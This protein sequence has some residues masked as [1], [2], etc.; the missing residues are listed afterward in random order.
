MVLFGAVAAVLLIVC[1]NLSNLL[2][3]RSVSRQREFAVR[4]ALGA[5]TGRLARQTLTETLVLTLAGSALGFAAAGWAVRAVIVTAPL[6]LPDFSPIAI[7]ARAWIFVSFL[8]L[9]TAPVVGALPAR[10]LSRHASRAALGD[11]ARSVGESVAGGRTS[12]V[13]VAAEV[14][15]AAMSLVVAGLLLASFARLMGVDKGF[16]PE[17]VLVTSAG[18]GGPV[19]QQIAFERRVLDTIRALPGVAAVGLTNKLPISGEGSNTGLR[20]TDGATGPN[21]FVTVDYRCVSPSYFGAI[22]IPLVRGRLFQD[23][24]RDHSVAL[25]SARAASRIWPGRNPIGHTFNLE[26]SNAAVEVVGIVGDV[27]GASRGDVWQLIA[28]QGLVPVAMGLIVG[29]A[30]AVASGQVLRGL[31]FGVT[32]TE[33]V[34]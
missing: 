3:S 1:V 24:D 18:V 28:R 26:G 4:A 29:L 15:L 14:A 12:R 19:V 10:R 20:P 7:D 9:V 33:P 16:A 2:L 17:R 23:S 34:P 13:L 11:N 27:H 32:V 5:R 30:G 22:G 21:D 6:G 8:T 31:L 25:L